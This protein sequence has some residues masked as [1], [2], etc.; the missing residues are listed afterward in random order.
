MKITH[1]LCSTPK[2]YSGICMEILN[3]RLNTGQDH[4]KKNCGFIVKRQMEKCFN[5]KCPKAIEKTVFT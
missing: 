2:F 3:I 5:R 4:I 1:I